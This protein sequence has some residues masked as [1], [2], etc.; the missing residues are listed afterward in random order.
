MGYLVSIH[1]TTQQPDAA[2]LRSLLPSS[3]GFAIYR[4][5]DLNLFGIDTFKASKPPSYP[6]ATATPA[7]DLPL[8]LGP[9]LHSLSDMYEVARVS[10]SANG[11]KRSY[12][13]LAELLSDGL[14]QPV[15]SIFSDDDGSDF[16][17]LAKAG[18]VSSVLAACDNN[19]VSLT[20]GETT[21]APID[22]EP[23][24]HSNAVR[25]FEHFTGAEA[26]TIGLGSWDPPADFGF[27]R[28]GT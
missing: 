21:V 19:L 11:I 9:H 24:L 25:L 13:N 20:N 23:A 15:L 10:G 26:Q 4:H 8:E 18:R 1:L 27:T 6:F 3:I 7:T 12:I 16:A 28:V 17:C 5:N 14:G 22:G 2:V